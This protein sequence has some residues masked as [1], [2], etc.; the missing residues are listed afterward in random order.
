MLFSIFWLA[1]I[2]CCR[3]TWRSISCLSCGWCNDNLLRGTGLRLRCWLD[4]YLSISTSR[5]IV[6][7]ISP[8]LHFKGV[9]IAW[10]LCLLVRLLLWVDASSDLLTQ[11]IILTLRLSHIVNNNLLWLILDLLLFHIR[12]ILHILVGM[13]LLVI[14]RLGLLIS[15]R[16]NVNCLRLWFLVI[17]RL[18]ALENSILWELNSWRSWIWCGILTYLL[19]RWKHVREADHLWLVLDVWVGGCGCLL[20]RWH[21]AASHV[22][23]AYA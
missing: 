15:K 4:C 12:L 17:Y 16:S 9:C 14:L 2:S 5:S 13:K 10:R 11:P 19:S 18:I 21:K 23:L 3:K 8:F 7:L 20:P 22:L 6:V 1:L